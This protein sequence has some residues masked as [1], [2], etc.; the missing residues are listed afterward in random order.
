M[1]VAKQAAAIAQSSRSGPA[2][3]V[4]SLLASLGQKS[5]ASGGRG[6]SAGSVIT[7]P[8][9]LIGQSPVQV[10]HPDDPGIILAATAAAGFRRVAVRGPDVRPT[11]AA[12]PGDSMKA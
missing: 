7:M 8:V 4:A 9:T 2:F 11:R 10:G 12:G 3:R 5:V 6:S 1:R